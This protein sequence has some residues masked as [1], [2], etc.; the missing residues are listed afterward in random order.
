VTA[1]PIGPIVSD[2]DTGIPDLIRRLTDDSKRLMTDEV[3]LAKMEAKDS[4]KRA[5]KG[6]LWMGLAFGAGVVALVAI[7]LFLVTLIGRLA[8]GHMWVGALV[9]GLLELGLGAWMIKKGITTIAEPSYTLEQSREALKDTANWA[10]NAA[11][12]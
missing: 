7:T 11:R 9:V 5:T 10:S 6:A 1:R 4:L 12:V 3:R 8:N 2:P